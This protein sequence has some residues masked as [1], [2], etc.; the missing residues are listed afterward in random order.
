MFSEYLLLLFMFMLF[1][2][3]P[4]LLPAGLPV[5]GLHRP[6]SGSQWA[7]GTTAGVTGVSLLHVY[8]CVYT[9]M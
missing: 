1:R 4:A 2:L 3:L 6:A 8:M 5:G 9:C 7:H